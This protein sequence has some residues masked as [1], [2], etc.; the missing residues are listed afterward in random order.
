MKCETCNKEIKEGEVYQEMSDGTEIKH[1]S[2][3]R[4]QIKWSDI[5]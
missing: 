4:E 2:C 1:T 3:V 5:F